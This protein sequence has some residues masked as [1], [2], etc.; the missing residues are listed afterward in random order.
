MR[1]ACGFAVATAGRESQR[2]AELSL[3]R[4]DDACED[5]E[6]LR[7]VPALLAT[8]G[9]CAG[10][11]ALSWAAVA[12]SAQLF[13]PT[14]RRTGDPSVV[15]LTFDDGPNPSVT[16]ELLDLLDHHRIRATFFQIG[17][18][19][20]AFPELAADIA[21]RGH[22]IGNHTDTHARLTFLSTRRIRDEIEGCNRSFTAAIGRHPRWMRPPFGY[23][24][25]QLDAAVR[26]GDAA[27]RIVMW[28]ASGRDW[29]PQSAERVINRLRRVRGG[30]IV[31]LHD[32]D[33]RTERGDRRHTIAA[34]TYW[35]PRW[36]DAGIRFMTLD[37][38]AQT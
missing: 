13:G 16:S 7:S 25:P 14:L 34:L 21:G 12:P 6:V 11:G 32:G 33:H 5:S 29:F 28:S 1:A 17:Q 10:C 19:I 26:K 20:R 31:L 35:L 36:K 23:R 9:F 22:A 24:G 3:A 4:L 18:R 2:A 15:A 37:D 38:L 30:D 27:A 8:A